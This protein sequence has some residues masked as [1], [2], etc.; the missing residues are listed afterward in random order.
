MTRI[1]ALSTLLALSACGDLFAD[2]PPCQDAFCE[3][4]R[5]E[6]LSSFLGTIQQNNLMQQEILANTAN[7]LA[8][9]GA[10]TQQPVPHSCI[11]PNFSA[12]M[13]LGGAHINPPSLP[14]LTMC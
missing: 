14:T 8:R 13:I 4:M 6:M 1:I 3:R 12:P 11:T 5:F 7:N 10:A 9:I 2:P